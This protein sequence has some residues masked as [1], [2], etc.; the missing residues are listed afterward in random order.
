MWAGNVVVTAAALVAALG[1]A[2]RPSPTGGGTAT[3]T[4]TEALQT[5]LARRG[6]LCVARPTWPVDVTEQD[7]AQRSRDALQLPVLE[8]LGVV[9]SSPATVR[10]DGEGGPA[11][12]SVRRY[13]LTGRGRSLYIDR[14]TRQP[15]SDAV[16]GSA[17]ADL[18]LARLTLDRITRVEMHPNDQHPAS[19]RV[20]YTYRVDAPDW[21]RDPEARRV[22]PAVARVIGGT[23]Q[24]ELEEG[25]VMTEAGWVA[26]ELLEASAPVATHASAGAAAHEQGR[27]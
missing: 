21:M 8:R 15:A 13:R 3:A 9:S 26:N 5:Y 25:L 2:R 6:D 4:V 17:Y 14:R 22:F 24:A 19:A 20:S 16:L 7:Q 27:P 23:G 12:V 1:C 11:L 10:V 18:C